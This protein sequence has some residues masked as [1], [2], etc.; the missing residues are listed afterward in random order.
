VEN[1]T[2]TRSELAKFDGRQGRPAYIA[3]HEKVYDVTASFSWEDGLHYDEH[4]A[5]VDH[6]EAMLEAPH[7]DESLDD[8]PVVGRLID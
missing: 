8:F 4:R 3:F 1:R 5:G 7:G 6:T 2:F